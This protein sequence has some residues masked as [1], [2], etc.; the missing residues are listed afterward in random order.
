MSVESIYNALVKHTLST[1]NAENG[2]VISVNLAEGRFI[3]LI[4]S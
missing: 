2:I 4:Y 3:H 1:M